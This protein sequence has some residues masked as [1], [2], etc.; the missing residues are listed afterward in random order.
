MKV[1]ITRPKYYTHLVTP[2]LGMAYV[3]AYLKH[4]GLNASIIDGLKENIDNQRLVLR[5]NDADVV[6]IFCMSDFFWD[7]LDLTKRLK[8]EGKIVVIGGPQ[9]TVMPL[10]TLEYTLADYAVVGEGEETMRQLVCALKEGRNPVNIPGVYSKN[11]KE[12]IA[13]DFFEDLDKIPFPAWSE[14]DPKAYPLAPHGAVVKASPVAP[15]T[16]S[17]GCPFSCHFCASP[18]IWN[19]KI[20][21]RSAKNVVDEIEM[22]VREYGVKEIHFEDD[23]L[24]LKRSHIQGICEEI[25]SRNIKVYWATPNGIRVDTV[26][27]E[28]LRLMKRSG[29]YSVAFGIESGS[30]EILDK[31]EKKTDLKIIRSAVEMAYRAGLITQAFIIFGLPGETE[32]TIQ[33]TINMVMKLPLHKVQFLL[34][35]VLPGS[36]LWDDQDRLD[37]SYFKKRSYQEPGYVPAGLTADYLVKVRAEAFRKFHMRPRQLYVFLKMLK[38]RQLKFIIQRVKD[39]SMF[40]K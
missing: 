28:L 20:R 2:P 26:S 17:R 10:K 11:T 12:F 25:L 3:C 18:K 4:A 22:L 9:A 5:C 37:I 14:I 7:V 16:S 6:G 23:N 38:L 15:V 8:N 31:I 32:K 1:I 13:R 39:F 21:Y 36:R 34:L 40:E 19:R 29:C 27:D 24:T 33:E 30:Q 35:D